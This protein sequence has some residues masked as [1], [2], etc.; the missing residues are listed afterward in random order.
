[1][2]MIIIL[3]FLTIV[4]KQPLAKYNSKPQW[5]SNVNVFANWF[6]NEKVLLSYYMILSK[7]K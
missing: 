3:F 7:N 5:H 4:P 2:T 6:I 1:M